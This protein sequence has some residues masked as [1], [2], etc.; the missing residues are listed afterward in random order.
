MVQSTGTVTLEIRVQ[1]MNSEV[2]N[3]VHCTFEQY[4]KRAGFPMLLPGKVG[5]KTKV[6][7]KKL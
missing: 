1:Y 6:V 2:Q 3:S 4:Q 5:F 7:T